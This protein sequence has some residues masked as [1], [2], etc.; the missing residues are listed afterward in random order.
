[1]PED[2]HIDLLSDQTSCHNA[3]DGGYCPVGIDL[4]P[5]HTSCCTHDRA[6]FPQAWWTPPCAATLTPSRPSPRRGTYFFDYG[7]SF[8]KAV[9]DSGVKEISKNGVDEKDGFIFPSYVEDIMG[10][11]LFDYGYGPFRWVCLSWQARGPATPPTRPPWTA[12]TRTA[13][14]QDRDNCVWVRDAREEPSSW[15]A[16]RPASCTRTPRAVLEDRP[17]LQ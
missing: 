7:N 12:S 13:G 3:Y 11:L 2:F 10:P 14:Y 5:A 9:Y 15:S 17:A 6:G 8:M 16:P 1:M 4:C